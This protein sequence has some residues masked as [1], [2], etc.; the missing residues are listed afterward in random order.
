MDGG[1]TRT[2]S[3][4]VARAHFEPAR[5]NALDALLCVHSYYSLG[6]GTASPRTLVRRAAERGYRYLALTDHLSVSGGVE[7]FEAAREHGVE[8]LIGA[9]LPVRI[10]ERAFP[11]VLIAQSRQGYAR[12][13]TMLTLAH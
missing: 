11:L 8:A 6:A 1:S 2:D 4:P 12:L 7:L 13:N 9:T 10:E 5:R 3:A